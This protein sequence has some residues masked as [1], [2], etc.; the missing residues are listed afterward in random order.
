MTVCWWAFRGTFGGAN[1]IPW[2]TTPA[3]RHP[4]SPTSTAMRAIFRSHS[5]ASGTKN[6]FYSSLSG[7]WSTGVVA[8]LSFISWIHR[9]RRLCRPEGPVNHHPVLFHLPHVVLI[10][11]AQD[12]L[13]PTGGMVSSGVEREVVVVEMWR[14]LENAAGGTGVGEWMRGRLGGNEVARQGWGGRS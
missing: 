5:I 7:C 10:F 11:T 6:R 9:L 4:R 2:P 8:G 1:G 12:L 14:V 3:A 13:R